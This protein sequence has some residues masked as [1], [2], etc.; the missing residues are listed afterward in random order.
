MFYYKTSFL[1]KAVFLE[2]IAKH[3]FVRGHDRFEGR[4]SSGDQNQYNLFCK[5]CRFEYFL[6]NNC[7]EKNN[8]FQNNSEKLFLGCITIF[9]GT[10]RRT[11][12]MNIT[13]FLGGD[14]IP[15]AVF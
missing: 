6:F 5:H 14:G 12:K 4:R 2:K 15:N 9:E 1:K 3:P 8:T 13:F 11:I 10:G 7:F